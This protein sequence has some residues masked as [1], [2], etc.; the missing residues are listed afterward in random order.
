V[1]V[2]TSRQAGDALEQ[3]FGRLRKTCDQHAG[4]QRGA[5]GFRFGNGAGARWNLFFFLLAYRGV[6]LG[7]WTKFLRFPREERL[8]VR[9]KYLLWHIVPASLRPPTLS[10]IEGPWLQRT[11]RMLTR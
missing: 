5:D 9:T 1:I 4:P 7:R 10:F 8:N 11:F 6:P 2:G 3:E